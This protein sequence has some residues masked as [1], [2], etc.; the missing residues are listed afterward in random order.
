MILPALPNLIRI[1]LLVV[2]GAGVGAVINW[3]IYQLQYFNKR[4]ISPWQSRDEQA[5]PRAT[6]DYI[7]I[8]GWFGIR[9]DAELHG[10]GFWIRPLLIEVVWAIGLPWFYNWQ[11]AG[12]LTDGMNVANGLGATVFETWFL[13]QA[14][15]IALMFAATFIDF[16][17]KMIPDAVTVTGTIFALFVAALAPLSRLPEIMNGLA[18][19]KAEFL[20]FGSP[21][22]LANWHHSVWGLV[23]ALLIFL[24]WYVALLP[25]W[26]D[27]RKGLGSLRLI[28]ASIVRPRRKTVCPLRTTPRQPLAL[29]RVL[30]L[31]WVVGT[32][33][34]TVA[35]FT[36]PA[37]NWTSLFSSLVGLG[38]GAGFVWAIRIVG[39]YAMGQEAMGFGD[40]VLMAMI[41]AFLGWQ[42]AILVFVL[43]PVSAFFI[44]IVYYLLTRK[45]ELAFGPYLCFGALLLILTWSSLWPRAATG[46]F[47]V[48]GKFLAIVGLVSLILMALMLFG[49]QWLKGPISDEEIEQAA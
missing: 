14:V 25:K 36:L 9:R 17:E 23:I 46:F 37:L 7:P 41:G 38:V 12:G 33:L 13:V 16:D 28:V 11:F 30:T 43:A 42:P 34:I 20:H 21:N 32:A 31:I 26:I 3:A 6:T 35:W 1:L 40:V 18:G 45:S 39:S 19:K 2:I 44:A 29:T 5:K 24:I 47:A 4:K 15:M 48:G 27:F 10:K 8:L 49:L 22:P